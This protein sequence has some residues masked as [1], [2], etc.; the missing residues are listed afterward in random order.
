MNTKYILLIVIF[1]III[2]LHKIFVLEPFY[3]AKQEIP[4]ILHL[5]WIGNKKAPDNL[6]TWTKNFKKINPDWTVKVWGNKEMDELQL[7]NR[8]QYDSMKE[9]CGKADIARYEI[10]YRFGGMYIDA[11]T[12]WLEN[13]IKPEFFKGSINLFY[14]KDNLIANGWIT[15]IKNHPFLKEVIYEIPNRDMSKPAWKCVGPQLITDVYNK[16]Q[17]KDPYDFHFVN[18]KDVLC[19]SSWFGINNSNYETLLKECKKEKRALAF[20]YGISTNNK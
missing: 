15:S 5:I 17:N 7:F 10:L 19:P 6:T 11:D 2:Y 13:P 20:H 3:C 1:I 12:V 4:K 8:K 9:Y 18:I 14:E 16:I